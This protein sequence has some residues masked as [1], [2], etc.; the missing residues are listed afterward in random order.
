MFSVKSK[1][2][3]ESRVHKDQIKVRIIYLRVFAA[4]GSVFILRWILHDLNVLYGQYSLFTLSF[5][6]FSLCI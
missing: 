2:S 3:K 5:V 6:A 1:S 4:A